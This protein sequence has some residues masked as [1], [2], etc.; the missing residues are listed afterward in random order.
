MAPPKF[1][2]KRKMNEKER[3]LKDVTRYLRCRLEWCRQTGHVYDPNEQYSVFHR[4]LCDNQGT[5]YSSPKS[6][7]I[8]KISS[9]YTMPIIQNESPWIPE[10]VIIDAMY[11]LHTRPMRT[12]S[13]I[14]EYSRYLFNR[15]VLPYLHNRDK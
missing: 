9:R 6:T 14:M 7:W 12:C 4:A 15:F 13:N 11:I 1:V 3:E 8:K 10:T 2:N 5:P